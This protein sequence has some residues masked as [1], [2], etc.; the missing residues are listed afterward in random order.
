MPQYPPE[1]IYAAVRA[2]LPRLDAD[3]RRQAE[4]L[5]TQAERGADTDLSL[6]DLLTARDDDIARQFRD[7]LKEGADAE[8]VLGYSGLPSTHPGVTPAGEMYVCPEPQCDYRYVIGETG[9]TPPPCPKHKQP[10]VPTRE[11]KGG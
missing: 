4:S 3:R 9:E 5:L 8:R 10:L 1:K 2:L 6:I 11:K 7:L